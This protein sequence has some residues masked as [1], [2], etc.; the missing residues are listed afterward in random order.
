VLL[1]DLYS[2]QFTHCQVTIYRQTFCCWATVGT[3]Y[4][5]SGV[6]Y[7]GQNWVEEI[8]DPYTLNSLH[9]SVSS[10]DITDN[11][12]TNVSVQKLT[13]A[14]GWKYPFRHKEQDRR[15]PFLFFYFYCL[16]I[17]FILLSFS[18]FFCFLVPL[19]ITLYI[20]SIQFL[21]FYCAYFILSPNSC[22]HY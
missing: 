4:W 12:Q 2:S 13:T 20:I 8:N 21:S 19:N 5:G 22:I 18:L 9:F 3:G 11:K 10:C 15:I 1:N 14:F 6:R 7:P 16:F 17:I